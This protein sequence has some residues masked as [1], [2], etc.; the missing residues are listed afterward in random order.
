MNDNKQ[1]I[2]SIY[3]KYFECVMKIFSSSK[4]ILLGYNNIMPVCVNCLGE[5]REFQHAN[6]LVEQA[7]SVR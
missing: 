6:W 4:S 2:E 3:I 1:S 7:V 5:F